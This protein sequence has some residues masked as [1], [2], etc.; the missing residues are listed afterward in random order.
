MRTKEFAHDYRYFPE[1]DLVP[2]QSEL[3]LAEMRPRVPE[4]P[5]GKAD[6]L[7]RAVWGERLRCRGAG[8]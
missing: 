8:E 1:P 3:L 6:A 5:D 7:R 2:V 4:L